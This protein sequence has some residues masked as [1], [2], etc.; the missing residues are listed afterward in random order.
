L[1]RYSVQD[2]Y[3][4]T[5]ADLLVGDEQ[6]YKA[7]GSLHVIGK[8]EVSLIRWWKIAS[9][10][11]EYECRRFKNFVFCSCLGFFFKKKMC[12]HLAITTNVYC[13]NCFQF[14]ATVGKLC[15]DCDMKINHFLP[16]ST[17]EP[18]WAPSNTL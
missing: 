7:T 1:S 16:K 6:F 3:E 12:K 11:K 8:G 2:L 18:T 5:D 14:S 10:D 17:P 13:S 9:G 4:Q 15:Y